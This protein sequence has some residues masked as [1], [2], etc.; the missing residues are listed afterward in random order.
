MR[1]ACDSL[2][3]LLVIAV[4]GGS[5]QWAMN[6]HKAALGAEQ[7][8]LQEGGPRPLDLSFTLASGCLQVNSSK[9]PRSKKGRVKKA[10]IY[11]ILISGHCQ[12][13]LPR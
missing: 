12:R 11:L 4:S 10:I 5:G 7:N 1:A 13:F 9:V 2:I 6:K 8:N 3:G